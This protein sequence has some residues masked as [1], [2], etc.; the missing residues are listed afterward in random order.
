ML[1]LA[2]LPVAARA[3][4]DEGWETVVGPDLRFRLEMPSPV[5]RSTAE[6]EQGNAAP[7]QA[8]ESK[9]SDQMFDFDYVDYEPS[10]FAGRDTKQIARLLGRG[11][12]EKAFPTNKFKYVRDEPVTLQGWDGYALDIEGEDGGVVMM[13]T[14]LV[15][16]RLYRMLAT[17]QGD[18][19]TRSAALRFIDSLRLADTKS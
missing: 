3:Q 4:T 17:A 9:R 11:E 18:M 16:D 14:Y 1:G 13:R 5:A 10:W 15:K 2:A 12:A 7:R 19:R 8:Y 6:K